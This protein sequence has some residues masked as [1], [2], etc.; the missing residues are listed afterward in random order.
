[1]AVVA[2]VAIGVVED[3]VKSKQ[4]RSKVKIFSLRK[5]SDER[6]VHVVSG[7]LEVLQWV[8]LIKG[9]VVTQDKYDVGSTDGL[10]T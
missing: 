9:I 8:P 1:M 10:H 7:C 6:C 5:L 3:A 2:V 4:K